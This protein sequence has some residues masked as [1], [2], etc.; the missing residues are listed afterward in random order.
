MARPAR[1]AAAVLGACAAA[2]FAAPCL[3]QGTLRVALIRHLDSQL[4]APRG[5]NWGYYSDP[6]LDTL[7]KVIR[8]NFDPE[9]QLGAIRKAHERF[10][11]EAL[12][13]Y[14]A[15]DVGPRA[16]SPRVKGFV[17]AQSWYQDFSPVA[18]AAK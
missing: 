13:L 10:V 16:L 14:V 1:I 4:V 18:V 15:H 2:A 7:F 17:Q 5:T 3:A 8:Y 9:V 11:N 6:E 12:F